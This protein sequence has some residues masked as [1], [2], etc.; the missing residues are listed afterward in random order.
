MRIFGFH[1]VTD[2][3]LTTMVQTGA[4]S[5][6]ERRAS[7][8]AKKYA[9]NPNCLAASFAARHG[10]KA[11]H[12]FMT[13]SLMDIESRAITAFADAMGKERGE[14]SIAAVRPEPAR[15]VRMDTGNGA[16]WEFG[17]GTHPTEASP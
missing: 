6:A 10:L 1:I 13:E 17:R 12:A 7:S 15:Y 3:D 2:R 5:L 16:D 9:R 8:I 4:A 11:E 14:Q